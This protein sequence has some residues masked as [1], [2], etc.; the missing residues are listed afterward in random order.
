MIPETTIEE[1]IAK[2]DLDHEVHL[3]IAKTTITK[4][5]ADV[6]SEVHLDPEAK[7]ATDQE[8]KVKAAVTHGFTLDKAVKKRLRHY[9]VNERYRET[10]KT[11]DDHVADETNRRRLVEIEEQEDQWG[12][13]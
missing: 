12:T 9:G 13:P 8:E 2:T 1:T 6:K 11:L 5:M 10:L 7:K 4:E 3:T